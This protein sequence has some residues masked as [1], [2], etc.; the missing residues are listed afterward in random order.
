MYITNFVCTY[1][2]HEEEL[3][4]DVYRSQMLQAFNLKKWDDEKI[5]T[6]TDSLYHLCKKQEEFSRI[7]HK[8]K[9]SKNMQLLISIMGDDDR[10]VFNYLFKFELFYL[11]HKIFCNIITETPIDKDAL[12]SLLDNIV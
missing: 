6:E 11:A 1:K 3:Q 9:T 7:L 8:L 5:N 2:L 12:Q 4:E 10:T